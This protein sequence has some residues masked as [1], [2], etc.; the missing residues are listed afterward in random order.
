MNPA[1]RATK[2]EVVTAYRTQEILAAARRSM[3]QRGLEVTMGEIA[4]AAGVAKGTLYLYFQGKEE[5]IHALMS[6]VGENLL[7]D[8]EAILDTPDSPPEK[9]QQVVAMLLRY[10][11][12]E[13]VLF[14]AYVRESLRKEQPTGKGPWRPVQ[15]L[16]EK[17]LTRLSRFF[18]QGMEAGA[19][20]D[21]NPR[22]LSLLLRGVIQAVG[23]YQMTEAPRDVSKEALPV[24][25]TLIT[26]GIVRQADSSLEAAK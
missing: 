1:P 10:V 19:F 6:Q 12:R 16:E 25:L 24:L 17:F 9:L 18:A 5:L 13:G 15:E 26:A 11:E 22:L 4:A 14:P 2:K 23:F 21:A 7:Q 20:Q 8:L 3:E